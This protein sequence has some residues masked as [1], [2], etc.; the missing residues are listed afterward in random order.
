M[1]LIGA[2]DVPA[3]GRRPRIHREARR[4]VGGRCAVCATSAWPSRALCHR[5]GAA[6]VVEETFAATGSLL[7]CANVWVARPGIGAP[8]MLGQVVLDDGPMVFAHIRGF[9][10]VPQTPV[11]VDLVVADAAPPFWFEPAHR[12][13]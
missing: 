10:D 2:L 3:T 1:G 4:L 6:A 13:R 8:Y 5:C 7:A 11:D 12:R 9:P